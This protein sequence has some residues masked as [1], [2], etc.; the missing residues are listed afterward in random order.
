ML[1]SGTYCFIN[2]EG[3]KMLKKNIKSINGVYFGKSKVK[4]TPFIRILCKDEDGENCNWTGWLTSKNAENV[5][6]MLAH[7]NL[8]G[9]IEEVIESSDED[10]PSFFSVPSE[11]VL[12]EEKEY[13][14]KTYRSIQGLASDKRLPEDNI[15]KDEIK[16][17]WKKFDFQAKDINELK[18]S[19]K[20][21]KEDNLPF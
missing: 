4:G 19:D 1:K 16:E 12:I 2:L 18:V 13:D 3:N 14:G 9:K 10:R 7:F 15:S 8:N 17:A 21:L 11:E 6:D 5:K 20:T